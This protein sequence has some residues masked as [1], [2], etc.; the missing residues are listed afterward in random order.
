[1]GFSNA[2]TPNWEQWV[3]FFTCQGSEAFLAKGKGNVFQVCITIGQSLLHKKGEKFP[4]QKYLFGVM[5]L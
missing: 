1:M 4:S 5:F 2:K 3:E